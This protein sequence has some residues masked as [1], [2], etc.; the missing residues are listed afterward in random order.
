MSVRNKIV[1]MASSLLPVGFMPP[2]AELVDLW[3]GDAA[4]KINDRRK[5][6]TK[7]EANIDLVAGTQLYDL[8]ED[9]V[10]IEDLIL[11]SQD[12]PGNPRLFTGFPLE[13]QI[14]PAMIGGLLPNGQSVTGSIDH[15]MRSEAQRVRREV[16]WDTYGG[17]LRIHF[18]PETGR[19][20]RLVYRVVDRDVEDLPTRYHNAIVT[21][22]RFMATEAFLTS[23]AMSSDHTGDSLARMNLDAIRR[24]AQTLRENWET[25][26]VGI[27][28]E[29]D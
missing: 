1:A 23:A 27:V 5:K 18:Q 25:T 17:Q 4:E 12:L 2:S 22:L 8:P 15:I 10:K 14:G 28:P 20:A 3:I 7:L 13:A 16:H 11:D 21:Y 24:A 9:C 19:K 6:T 26:L 29:V